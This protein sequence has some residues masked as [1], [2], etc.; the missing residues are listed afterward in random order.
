MIKAIHQ[1]TYTCDRCGTC[2]IMPF[3]AGKLAYSF[4]DRPEGM[5]KWIHIHQSTAAG[6]DLIKTDLCPSCAAG[7]KLYL[8]SPSATV[9]A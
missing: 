1:H 5:E 9:I 4:F 8:S 7:I 3:T 6:K 2:E